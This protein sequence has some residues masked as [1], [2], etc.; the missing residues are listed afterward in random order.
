[1]KFRNEKSAR[2]ISLSEGSTRLAAVGAGDV[3]DGPDG[4]DAAPDVDADA[5][6]DA[7]ASAAG[8][9][10]TIGNESFIQMLGGVPSSSSSVASKLAS[11]CALA[12]ASDL[13]PGLLLRLW[14]S[15]PA[16]A[17]SLNYI[18]TETEPNARRRRK[19]GNAAEGR[20]LGGGGGVGRRRRRRRRRTQGR[21]GEVQRS[22]ARRRRRQGALLV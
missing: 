3:V 20:G 7:A 9:S 21:R 4:A 15:A 6:A 16:I 17:A 11:S 14:P 1:M 2:R 8:A 12:S 22:E 13:L 10:S 18:E 5:D 19:P